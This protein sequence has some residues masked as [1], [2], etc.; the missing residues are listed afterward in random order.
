[1]WYKVVKQKPPHSG[2]YF[3]ATVMTSQVSLIPFIH[4]TFAMTEKFESLLSRMPLNFFSPGLSITHFIPVPAKQEQIIPVPA[5]QDD[6]KEKNS[7][8]S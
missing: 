1:M 8:H 4:P 5:K 3:G 2:T 6:L 7:P